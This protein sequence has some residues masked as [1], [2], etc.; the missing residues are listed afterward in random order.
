MIALLL[1]LIPIN[2]LFWIAQSQVWNTYNLWVR[3]HV[4]LRLGGW[5]M[6]VPWLQSLDG[7]A[8]F[9][10]LLTPVTGPWPIGRASRMKQTGQIRSDLGH[11]LLSGQ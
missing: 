11:R 6:P 1:A 10:C 8:P 3:D 9:V 2:A 5:T 4:E 7:L